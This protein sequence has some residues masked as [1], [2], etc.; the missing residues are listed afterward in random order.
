MRTRMI[1]VALIAAIASFVYWAIYS[2]VERQRFEESLSFYQALQ[3]SRLP[4]TWKISESLTRQVQAA[5][6][7]FGSVQYFIIQPGVGLSP[8]LSISTSVVY[9]IRNGKKYRELLDGPGPMRMSVV[10]YDW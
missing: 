2:K 6:A 7:K 10:P 8:G 4:N 9:T 3:T 5:D 1:R